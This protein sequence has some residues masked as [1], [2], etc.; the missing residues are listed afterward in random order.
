[1]ALD[2]RN[3]V[4]LSAHRWPPGDRGGKADVTFSGGLESKRQKAQG[5]DDEKVTVSGKKA[6]DVKIKIT[7][8]PELE[9][10]ATEFIDNVGP[11]GLHAGEPHEIVHPRAPRYGVT[12]VLLLE[13]GEIEED[14]DQSSITF[15]GVSWKTPKPTSAGGAKGDGSAA[16][17]DRSMQ[18]KTGHPPLGTVKVGSNGNTVT[19]F[20][21]APPAPAKPTVKP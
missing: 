3:V 19:G 16:T 7:W 11:Y 10:A 18:W 21:N 4:K 12:S 8:K 2:P 6:V 13:Q 17:P 20:D 5:K 15:K 14:V 1:M 9:G